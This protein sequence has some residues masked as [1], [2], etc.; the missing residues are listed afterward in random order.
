[1]DRITK[2]DPSAVSGEST[3]EGAPSERRDLSDIIGTWVS[4][5]EF[6][7]AIADQDRVDEPCW[8]AN[9]ND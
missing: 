6:D 3:A 4:D 1:M 7:A 8:I 2:D 5:P 9:D